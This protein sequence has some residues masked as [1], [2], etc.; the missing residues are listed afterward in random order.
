MAIGIYAGSF[1]PPTNGHVWIIKAGAEIFDKLV[2]AVGTNPAKKYTFSA[3]ER[4]GMLKEI[5]AQQ[6]NTSVVTLEKQFL[7]KFAK[8]IGA[9]YIL[10]GLRNE[11]DYNYECAANNI[12]NDLNPDIVTVCLVTPKELAEVSSG[13]VKSLVGYDGWEEVVKKYVP[14]PVQ[15]KML[16]K[17]KLVKDQ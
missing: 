6:K 13:M 15:K 7:A 1:D 3:E 5:V 4:I 16:E 9:K 17:F 8:S 14:E 12:N 11:K 10:R 2:V